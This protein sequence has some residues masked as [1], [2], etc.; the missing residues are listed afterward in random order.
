MPQLSREDY[1]VS[2]RERTFAVGVNP[3]PGLKE[4]Q[5]Q[6]VVVKARSAFGARVLAHRKVAIGRFRTRNMNMWEF[7]IN[8]V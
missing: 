3:I 5:P 7:H 6:V 2:A 8:E 4:P 1:L